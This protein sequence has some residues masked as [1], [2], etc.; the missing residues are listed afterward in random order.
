MV[1][2]PTFTLKINHSCRQIYH[3]YIDP[4]GFGN[5]YHDFGFRSVKIQPINAITE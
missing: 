2:F 3:N 1:Y 4:M 5:V